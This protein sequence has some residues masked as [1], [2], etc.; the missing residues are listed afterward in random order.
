MKLKALGIVMLLGMTQSIYANTELQGT[1]EDIAVDLG[2]IEVFAIKKALPGE[3]KPRRSEIDA[4]PYKDNSLPDI[5]VEN[6][7]SSLTQ[8]TTNALNEMAGVQITGGNRPTSQSIS[9]SGLSADRVFV[10]IDGINNNL[11]SFGHNQTRLLPDQVLYKAVTASQTGSNIS[12]GNGDLGGAINFETLDPNDLLGDEDFCGKVGLGGA[13]GDYSGNTNAA[14]AFKTGDLSYLF[15]T[16]GGRSNNVRLGNGQTLPDSASNNL[17]YLAK[18]VWDVTKAQTIKVSFLSMQNVGLYPAT[19]NKEISTRNPSSNFNYFQT[20]SMLD[21]RF[22][23]DNVYVDVQAKL[24]YNENHFSSFPT[25][26]GMNFALTQDVHANTTGIKLSNATTIYQQHLFYGTDYS[27]I[28]GYDG[29][30]SKTTANFP[31]ATQELYSTYLQ[32]SWDITPRFNVTVGGRF[33]GYQSK[34]GSSTSDGTF[35]TKE[36]SVSYKLIDPLKVYIGYT[37]GYRIPS[38]QDLYLGGDHSGNIPL[39]FEPNPNLNPETGHNKTI[40]FVYA[41]SMVNAQKIT[42][43]GNVFL[44]DIDDYILNSSLGYDATLGKVVNQNINIPKAQTYGFN[45]SA[46]YQTIWFDAS[47]NFTYTRGTTKSAYTDDRGQGI[48]AGS[49]LPIPRAKGAVAL[50]VPIKGIDSTVQTRFDYALAQ[51]NVPNNTPR[52]PGYALLGLSHQ[53]QPSIFPGFGLMAG[54]DNIFDQYYQDYDGST[55]VPAMGR[56]LYLQLNY[57]F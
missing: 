36:A 17:Q 16:V 50:A 4:T 41:Q 12:Y 47:S 45:L 24:Y 31:T 2:E 35:F 15:D 38:V 55:L 22:N 42:F 29:Y 27:F 7:A 11:A 53:W 44:N 14:V 19:I 20:Q 26:N 48:P 39:T 28:N 13:T 43:A 33:N 34:G 37:E 32:D 57:R 56:S 3:S 1:T 9:M 52:V 54:V 25:S 21:Y 51:N 30:N 46:G 49:A 18:A 6:S 40:G 5:A 23:P 8:S 10:G